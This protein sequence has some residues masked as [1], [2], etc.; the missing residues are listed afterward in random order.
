MKLS[1]INLSGAGID[2]LYKL[3]VLGACEDGD[4]PSKTGMYELISRGLALKN[5]DLIM[6]NHPTRLG[7]KFFNDHW[8]FN[9][10]VIKRHPQGVLE[11]ILGQYTN[12]LGTRLNPM[13]SANNRR[14]LSRVPQDIQCGSEIIGTLT[15]IYINTDG[16]ETIVS[17][18]FTPSSPKHVHEF[19]N[20]NSNFK[21]ITVQI[22]HVFMHYA[23]EAVP[24]FDEDDYI[25]NWT[26]DL[27][28]AK[29]IILNRKK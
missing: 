25:C 5:Y 24:R 22:N 14:A 2:V 9:P 16:N 1:T 4:L 28:R 10:I 17:G 12:V 11:I 15:S 7:V 13:L 29:A 26:D 18:C 27:D 23:L 6:S 3:C 20:E 21:I 19:L 8:E